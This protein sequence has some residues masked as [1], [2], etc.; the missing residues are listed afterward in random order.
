LPNVVSDLLEKGSEIQ[1]HRASSKPMAKETVLTPEVIQQIE[2]TKEADILIGIPAYNNASTIGNVI[3]TV[4]TGLDKHFSKYRALI[5]TSDGDWKDETSTAIK[6]VLLEDPRLII[7]SRSPYRV[8]NTIPAYHGI[9]DRSGV[10]RTLFEIAQ[11][12]GV[13]ACAFVDADLKSMTPEWIEL[14]VKPVLQEGFD[15]VTPFYHRHKYD[16]TMTTGIIYPLTRALYGQRICQPIG[17]DFGFS[18]SLASHYLSREEWH[19]GVAR[20]GVDL[21]MTTTAIAEGF[22]VCQSFL[23]AKIPES[24]SPASDLSVLLSQVVGAA[25]SLMETY[26][27]FWFSIKGSEPTSIYGRRFEV[28]LEPVNVNL[29]RM[30]NAYRQ[31]IEDLV[32]IWARILPEETLSGLKRLASLSA[33]NFRFADALWARTV[34]DFAVAHFQNKMDRDHLVKSMTPLYLGRTASFVLETQDCSA[35][36]VENRIELLC[37]EYENLKPYLIDRWKS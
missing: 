7:L 8:N 21:W 15:Y 24:R 27:H 9:P 12:L 18:G 23:G 34:Y 29:D 1:Y 2:K 31:G 6:K 28:G 11:N 17:G 10:Y 37:L 14:L 33:A 25:F 16:G 3:R 30:I 13:K 19:T 20:Y 4:R 36:E 5:V 26:E 22:R 32:G 35:A